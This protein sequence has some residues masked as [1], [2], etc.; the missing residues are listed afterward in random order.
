MRY[1][2]AVVLSGYMFVATGCVTLYKPN[3]V[4]SPLVKEK[5]DSNASASLGVSGTG[6]YNFQAATALSDHAGIMADGMYHRRMTNQTDSSYENLNLL[7]GEAGG[8]YFTRF[9]EDKKGL[10]QCYGGGG[11]GF[12]KD[13]MHNTRPPEPEVSSKFMN[14]FVQPGVAYIDDNFEAAFDIRMNYVQLFKIH[15]YLYNEFEWWNTDF[16]YY[17]DTTLNFVNIEPAITVKAGGEKLKGILQFGVTI[18]TIN[19][20]SYFMA[21]SSSMLLYPLIKFSLGI[22]YRFGKKHD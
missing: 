15:A 3:A 5:G 9:G 11:F 2:S 10:L 12:S 6:L 17:A 20:K 22:S 13:V 8:G 19:P 4:H 18:P 16:V 1:P 7:F 21:S 14:V